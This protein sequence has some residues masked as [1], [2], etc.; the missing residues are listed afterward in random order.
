M[1]R[2]LRPVSLLRLFFRGLLLSTLT[3]VLIFGSVLAYSFYQ[4]YQAGN[5]QPS[6][7]LKADAAV[8]LG[9]AAWDK[10]PSPVFRERIN[11]AITLY[12]GGNVEKLIFTGGTPKPGFMTEAEV[13]RRY[14]LRQG[15]PRGDILYENTSRDT[16]ENLR[17]IRPLLRNNDIETVIIVSDPIHLARAQ[18]MADDLG[19]NA[20]T[21][22]T[23]TTLY[24]DSEKRRQFMLQETY[25][26][27][28]Y[29][30]AHWLDK[31][32]H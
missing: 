11:H 4:V 30:W 15:I 5:A 7:T 3:G 20:R 6:L 23:P 18:A 16:Y 9:A 1:T 24:T 10:N 32:S 29:Y 14:A 27:F 28:A 13:G 8:V 22:G 12:Q 25:A 26:L 17:N 2:L 31:L 19:I 21:S